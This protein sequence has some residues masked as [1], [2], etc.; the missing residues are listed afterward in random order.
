MAIKLPSYLYRSRSG[1]LHFRIAI[2][3]DLRHHFVSREIYRSLRTASVR[4]AALAAQTLSND[5]KR[6]FNAIRQQTMSK[7]KKQPMEPV[8]SSEWGLIPE[9]SF[10][11]FMRP[12]LTLIP[13]PGDTPEDRI[14][15]QEEFMRAAGRAG[16][17]A[18]TTSTAPKKH[19][20]LFSELVEDYKRD[21]LALTAARQLLYGILE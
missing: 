6:V 14:Q 17:G 2:P 5:L 16:A 12:K 1:V 19:S 8:D 11:E 9:L 20:P 3:P 10:D 21:R 13:E 4:D 15:A 18:Q 7:Q